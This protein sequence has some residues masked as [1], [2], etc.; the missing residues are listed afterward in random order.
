V[1]EA[2]ERYKTIEKRL[3]EGRDQG[4]LSE[5]ED[6]ETCEE[7]GDLWYQMF[8]EE[9]DEANARAR[10]YHKARGDIMT[11]EKKE[12]AVEPKDD[13]GFT[14][15][16]KRGEEDAEPQADEPRDEL[17][18]MRKQNPEMVKAAERFRKRLD[19]VRDILREI[20][21]DT[22]QVPFIF[23]CQT[24][25]GHLALVRSGDD[26]S[27]LGLMSI[28]EG[29]IQY[30]NAMQFW[31]QVELRQQ[32]IVRPTGPPGPGGVVP[33]SGQSTGIPDKG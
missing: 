25:P 17:A 23:V 8:R 13:K 24:V 30:P 29:Y 18:E 22:P 2:A 16:D 11:D 14:V 5:E 31:Q 27:Q 26:V 1:T 21:E 33:L 3:L 4:T 28:V 9:R 12:E 19:H 20:Q 15:T 7:M 6:D 32:G 10:E